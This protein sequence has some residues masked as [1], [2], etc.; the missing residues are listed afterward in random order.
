MEPS[1][2]DTGPRHRDRG[3]APSRRGVLAGI[4]SDEPSDVD[5]LDIAEDVDTLA[6]LIAA[7]G[8]EAPLAI[9]VLGE[10]SAG[11]STLLQQVRGQ[12]DRLAALS[13]NNLGRSTY[14]ASIRQITLPS[15]SVNPAHSST[16]RAREAIYRAGRRSKTSSRLQQ[17]YD[18]MRPG[19]PHGRA[20]SRCVRAGRNR[21]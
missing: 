10:W 1:Q 5:L 13:L 21:P 6:T 16:C 17:P 8:T 20:S 12:V 18:A 3:R 14:A 11:K 4:R 15:A 9:A 2:R 7:S 19:R